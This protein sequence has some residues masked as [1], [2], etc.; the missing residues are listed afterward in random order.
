MASRTF[1][2]VINKN[3]GEFKL[4]KFAEIILDIMGHKD[5][6]KLPRHHPDLVKVIETLGYNANHGNCIPE[7]NKIDVNIYCIVKNFR[8]KEKI[9]TPSD[10]EWIENPKY[11]SPIIFNTKIGGKYEISD[12]AYDKY[13]ELTGIELDFPPPR[14]DINFI[15][16]CAELGKKCSI[17]YLSEL[18][19]LYINSFYY[20]IVEF[21]DGTETVVVPANIRWTQFRF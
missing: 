20:L 10:I 19:Y 2:I 17:E 8:G 21:N 3:Y 9:I 18:S 4:S 5:Y 1:K 12:E 16:V 11:Y 7:I 13:E 6:L 14:H 15:K